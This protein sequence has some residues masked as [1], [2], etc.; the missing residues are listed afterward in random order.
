MDQFEA[1]R[2]DTL[3]TEHH[4]R[5]FQK[6]TSGTLPDFC[7]VYFVESNQSTS[8]EIFHLVDKIL[9]IRFSMNAEGSLWRFIET[10]L[11]NE[12]LFSFLSMV[13]IK[14]DHFYHTVNDLR[15]FNNLSFLLI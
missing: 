7:G 10:D 15:S 11:D 14:N 3:S 8:S 4:E 13:L 9:H 1:L 6:F 5:E 12:N 2:S